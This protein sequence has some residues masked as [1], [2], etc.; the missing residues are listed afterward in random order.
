MRVCVFSDVDVSRL[1]FVLDEWEFN[2]EELFNTISNK[3]CFQ[4]KYPINVV[5]I[6]PQQ[7]K[8]CTND[9]LTIP[10]IIYCGSVL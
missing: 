3:I 2:P 6:I 5:V 1:L 8:K 7:F 9:I 10:Q 4:I